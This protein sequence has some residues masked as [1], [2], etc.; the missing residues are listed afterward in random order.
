[1]AVDADDLV[2]LDIYADVRATTNTYVMRLDEN[3]WY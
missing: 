2:L 1:M 3:L